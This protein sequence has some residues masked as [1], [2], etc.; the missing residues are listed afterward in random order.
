MGETTYQLQNFDLL[1]VPGEAADRLLAAG[2][3]DCALLYLY[4]LRCGGRFDPAGAAKLLKKTEAAVQVLAS[5]LAQMGVLRDALP[6]AP[7][8]ELPAYPLEDILQR[9]REDNAFRGLWQE[10]ER[11]MGR[12]LSRPD[13]QTL[14]GI[15]DRLGMSPEVIMLLINHVAERLRKR[16]GEGRLPTMH[17]IEKEAFI[18]ARREILTMPQ[19]ESYLEEQQ[20]LASRA[21]KLRHTLQITGREPTP[22]ERRYMEAWFSMG[23]SDEVFSLAYDR[24]VTQT[25]KLVWP[26][27]DK[28]LRSWYE[29]KLFTLEDIEKGDARQGSSRRKNRTGTPDPKSGPIHDDLD[30]LESTQRR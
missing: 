5:R 3:G 6:V 22:T 15:Y 1:S 7:A 29:K 12:S 23:F 11:H 10:C 14:F 20:R 18:W 9:S 27:M 19:A 17:A 24:T 21:E 4:I 25:G 30:F 16:Y 13:L 8:E 2:D 26:Y 28:I